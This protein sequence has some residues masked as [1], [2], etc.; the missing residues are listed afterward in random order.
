ML[1]SCSG[2]NSDIGV[3]IIFIMRIESIQLYGINLKETNLTDHGQELICR[4]QKYPFIITLK[5]NKKLP[6]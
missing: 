4:L 5:A 1:Y 2:Q 3:K 6:R